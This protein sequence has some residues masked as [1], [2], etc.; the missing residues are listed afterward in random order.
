MYENTNEKKKKKQ[1][2]KKKQNKKFQRAYPY[3]S[4][5]LLSEARDPR[6]TGEAIIRI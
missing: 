4:D 1:K 6:A 5:N 2:N 3:G